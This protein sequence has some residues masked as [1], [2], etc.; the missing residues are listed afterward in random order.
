M[1]SATAEKLSAENYHV[2]QIEDE[3]KARKIREMND[4][5][6]EARDELQ[7][8][9]GGGTAIVD[10]T[11]RDHAQE[12]R[13]AAI[14]R[15]RNADAF[16]ALASK[17]LEPGEEEMRKARVREFE[18][19]FGEVMDRFGEAEP[20]NR[21]FLDDLSTGKWRG[22]PIAVCRWRYISNECWNANRALEMNEESSRKLAEQLNWRLA[23]FDG[24]EV[25][26]VKIQNALQ[27]GQDLARQREMWTDFIAAACNIHLEE[28][29]ELWAPA[30]KNIPGKEKT[31]A[32]KQ[33]R[34]YVDR[35]GKKK[36][37]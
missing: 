15:T 20:E 4:A 13:D 9:A 12:A 16:N 2:Q 28:V 36:T 10:P 14:E 7:L 8:M 32:A 26:D 5:A 3:R 30:V 1:K 19:A 18:S 31:L 27:Y 22:R 6:Q 24:A 17:T 34:A 37:A 35:W 33:A 25:D 21:D 11:L 29:D 23:R